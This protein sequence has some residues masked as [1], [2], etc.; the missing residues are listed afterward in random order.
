M[1]VTIPDL[2]LLIFIVFTGYG[3]IFIGMFAVIFYMRKRHPH[4]VYTIWL[5]ISFFFTVILGAGIIAL[6]NDIGLAEV[7]GTYKHECEKLYEVMTNEEDELKLVGVF[8]AITIIPQLLAYFLSALSGSA[9]APRYVSTIQQAAAWSLIKFVAGIGGG[10]TGLTVA[11]LIVRGSV[12]II[13][14][15]PGPVLIAV[16]FCLAFLHLAFWD[17]W[18]F[19][20]E[21]YIGSEGSKKFPIR[22]LVA[23]HKWSTRN[24]PPAAPHSLTRHALIELLKSD[25]V[26]DYISQNRKNT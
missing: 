24:V 8:V 2:T 13:N 18:D 22:T 1:P 21:R 3:F 20:S 26:Y 17:L 23:I 14:I 9:T 6:R 25:A 16:A 4:E 10:L 7:C 12:E 5:A 19:L 11:T 15:V